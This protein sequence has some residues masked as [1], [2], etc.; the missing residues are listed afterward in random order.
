MIE[1]NFL[2]GEDFSPVSGR[3]SVSHKTKK[4]LLSLSIES[5]WTM[6]KYVLR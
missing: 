5:E 1:Y 6:M 3:S 4:Y 2:E